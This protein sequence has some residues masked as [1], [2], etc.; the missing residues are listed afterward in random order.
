MLTYLIYTKKAKCTSKT[1]KLKEGEREKERSFERIFEAL[2]A[3]SSP[4]D[5][6]FCNS[7]EMNVRLVTHVGRVT[8]ETYSSI[9]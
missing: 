2:G 9:L 8:Y 4:Q 7:F 1:E 5:S 6:S 3:L